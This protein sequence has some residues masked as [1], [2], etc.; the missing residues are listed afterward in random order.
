MLRRSG[1]GAAAPGRG[2]SGRATLAIALGVAWL[3]LGAVVLAAC[4]QSA[5]RPEARLTPPRCFEAAGARR[6]TRPSDIAFLV[7]ALDRGKVDKPA[8][9]HVSG[10][11]LHEY[12]PTGISAD[13]PDNSFRAYVGDRRRDAGPKD[14]VASSTGYVLYVRNASARQVRMLEDC[15]D[16]A[17][18][19]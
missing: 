5:D 13:R 11:W 16:R 14:V 2:P 7:E 10:Y 12:A 17:A 19:L 6:A 8:G 18:G 1:R 3:A 15:F 4:G 9:A